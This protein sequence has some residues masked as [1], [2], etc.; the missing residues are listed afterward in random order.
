M[1]L[2]AFMLDAD[3]E[4]ASFLPNNATPEFLAG[5]VFRDDGLVD[6]RRLQ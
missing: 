4:L 3:D 6:V 2:A 5:A 1:Y